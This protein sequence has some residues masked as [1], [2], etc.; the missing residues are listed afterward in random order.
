MCSGEALSTDLAARFH[1]VL[2]AQ[3][4]N[5]YGPTE[6]SVD[7]T[8]HRAGPDGTGGS[9]PIGC[10]VRNTR[11]YV[12]DRALRPVPPGV[13]GELYLAGDQLARGYAG[14]P[15]LTAERFV[16]S[17]FGDGERL[18]RTGDLV[19]W[20]RDGDLVFVGRADPQAKLRS[21]R[22]ELD[23]IA[24]VLAAVP[25]VSWATDVAHERTPGDQLLVAYVRCVAGCDEAALRAPLPDYMVPSAFVPLTS[26]KL[27]RP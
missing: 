17:P 4:H 22:I 11:V 23:E 8:F 16:A 10:P 27:A 24:T 1:H 13:I 12:L 26:G 15:A 19:R 14:R 20:T 2:D 9:V 5:L 21:L 3:L 7:V 25:G 6:A 18:Y